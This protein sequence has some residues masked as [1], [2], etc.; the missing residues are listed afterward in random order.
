MH[1][2]SQSLWS[3]DGEEVHSVTLDFY[4]FCSPSSFYWNKNHYCSFS[5]AGQVLAWRP[6]RPAS[7]LPLDSSQSEFYLKSH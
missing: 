1:S 3:S 4:F 2:P 7:F 6:R 5:A